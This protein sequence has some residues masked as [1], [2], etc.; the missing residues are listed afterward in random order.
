M[1]TITRANA[2]NFKRPLWRPDPVGPVS[3]YK[4]YA[5]ARPTATHWRAASCS[6]AGCLAHRRGW[7][8]TV[9]EATELGAR[10]AAYIRSLSRRRF[11]EA[12]NETGLTVFTF[13]SGQTC[14][15]AHRVPADRPPL[16]IV[17]QGDHRANLGGLRT[18]R[19]DQWL[20]DF[21]SHQER[22]ADQVNR[23]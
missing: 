14:F 11:T 7:R 1:P 2:A 5:V 15:A 20:E 8:T 17:R 22:L 16:F 21:G 18:L 23:G 10:Q 9:D 6:E 3:A 12:R 13:E 19:S 4:T